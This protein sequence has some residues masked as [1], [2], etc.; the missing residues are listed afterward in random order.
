MRITVVGGNSGTGAQVVRIAVQQGHQVTCLSRSGSASLPEGVRDLR[1][2]ALQTEVVRSA[3]AGADA[4]VVTVG[5][6]SGSGR[7]RAVQSSPEAAT[8][9]SC[10]AWSAKAWPNTVRANIRAGAGINCIESP[11]PRET[12]INERVLMAGT[13]C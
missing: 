2:D 10:S 8:A 13:W 7:H 12:L 9:A 3:V 5:G 11:T 4:V 6:A 1:G